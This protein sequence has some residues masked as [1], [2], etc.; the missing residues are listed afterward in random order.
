MFEAPG[1]TTWMPTESLPEIRLRDAA[2]VPPIK[3]SDVFSMSTPM[4]L[5]LLNVPVASVPMKLASISAF[6]TSGPMEVM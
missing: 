1:P 6:L 3:F 2:V 4:W 5:G